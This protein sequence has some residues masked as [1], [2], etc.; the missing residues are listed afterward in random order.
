MGLSSDYRLPDPNAAVINH[1]VGNARVFFIP[2]YR[3]IIFNADLEEIIKIM[4]IATIKRCQIN[5]YYQLINHNFNTT[6]F[7]CKGNQIMFGN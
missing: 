6:T 3:A 4:A 2:A 1:P 5:L 7:K